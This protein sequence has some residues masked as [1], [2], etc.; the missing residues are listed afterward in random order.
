MKELSDDEKK[1]GE[2]KWYIGKVATTLIRAWEGR[3]DPGSTLFSKKRSRSTIS[4]YQATLRLMELDI[5][6]TFDHKSLR[7]RGEPWRM[8]LKSL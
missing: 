8:N 5:S 4:N 7:D 1:K 2:I 3:L 6:A